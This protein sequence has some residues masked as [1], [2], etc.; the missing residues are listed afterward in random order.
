MVT[1]RVGDDHSDVRVD[2]PRLAPS[3]PFSSSLLPSS[4]R[5][6]SSPLPPPIFCSGRRRGQWPPTGEVAAEGGTQAGEVAAKGVGVGG[7]GRA[8]GGGR[9]GAA[10]ARGPRAGRRTGTGRVGRRVRRRRGEADGDGRRGGPRGEARWP[11]R[12]RGPTMCGGDG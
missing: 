5:L 11:G 4:S 10:A 7:R 8:G 12:R 2:G 9:A 1:T 3:F 6:L